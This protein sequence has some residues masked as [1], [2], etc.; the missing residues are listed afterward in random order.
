MSEIADLDRLLPE[1]RAELRE[2][3]LTWRDLREH[4]N[5]T[6]ADKLRPKIKEWNS[7][8]FFEGLW[9]P[10]YESEHNRLRRALN[11]LH[12]Y[13]EVDNGKHT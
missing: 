2:L 3:Y 6:E 10:Q 8:L 13:S 7:N 9:C 4:K 5:Y 12:K 11:R 1:E